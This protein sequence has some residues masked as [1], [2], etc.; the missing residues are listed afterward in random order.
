MAIDS[1]FKHYDK[2]LAY[3][4]LLDYVVVYHHFKYILRIVPQ[5]FHKVGTEDNATA[6]E[7]K[8]PE[9]IVSD[10]ALLI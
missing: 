8:M 3:S 5:K 1:V 9:I 2:V 10:L 7:Q 4:F 6:T